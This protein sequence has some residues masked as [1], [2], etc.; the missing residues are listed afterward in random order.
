MPDERGEP[1]VL[2]AIRGLERVLTLAVKALGGLLIVAMVIAVSIG[3]F[4]RYVLLQ[5]VEWS[6]EV[7]RFLMV[8]IAF[9]GAAVGVRARAHYGILLV[10][11]RFPER[12]QTALVVFGDLCVL[13]F[14]ALLIRYGLSILEVTG[15]QTSPTLRVPLSVPYTVIPLGGALMAF[16][17]LLDLAELVA[18]GG[19]APTPVFAAHQEPE[20][21]AELLPE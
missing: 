15:L 21:A 20:R 4:T 16:Y 19:A 14:A 6:E 2:G 9:L 7:A 5:P 1:S 18:R 3:V 10:T 8:W 11:N 12:L 17:V 13:L